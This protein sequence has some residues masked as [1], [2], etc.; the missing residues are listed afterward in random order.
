MIN[1]LSGLRQRV[2]NDETDSGKLTP[3]PRR[4]IHSYKVTETTKQTITRNK[5][6]TETKD[7]VRKVERMENG[8]VVG[9]GEVKGKTMAT[10]IK[11]LLFVAILVAIYFVVVL[12]NDGTVTFDQIEDAINTAAKSKADQA[13]DNLP[14]PEKV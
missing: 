4:S 6:G 2:N 13:Q 8:K 7:V 1:N 9:D 11:V 3:T 14:P 12:Q 10:L 5:D